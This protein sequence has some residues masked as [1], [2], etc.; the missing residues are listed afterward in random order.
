MKLGSV[1]LAEFVQAVGSYWLKIG[2]P[3]CA[4]IANLNIMSRTMNNTRN[5][6]V[7]DPVNGVRIIAQDIGSTR[8]CGRH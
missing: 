8:G 7:N 6:T 4:R 3:G 1:R 2:S 5:S